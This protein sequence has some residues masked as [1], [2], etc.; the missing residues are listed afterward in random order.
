MKK[1]V[2][3]NVSDRGLYYIDGGRYYFPDRVAF[4]NARKGLAWV[5]V[6]KEKETFGFVSGYMLPNCCLVLSNYGSLLAKHGGYYWNVADIEGVKVAWF[7]DKSFKLF[8]NGIIYDN[9]G[10]LEMWMYDNIQQYEY[11][12]TLTLGYYIDERISSTTNMGDPKDCLDVEGW[13]YSKGNDLY[14]FENK[15]YM[16]DP[17][18]GC[19]NNKG[20]VVLG[21]HIMLNTPE[22]ADIWYYLEENYGKSKR[23][24]ESSYLYE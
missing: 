16:F 4:K 17:W 6:I 21:K 5:E 14:E 18:S 3:L 11:S 12:R 24:V 7:Y 9:F 23:L 20:V 22:T 2:Y 15:V 19:M 13:D 10:S 8:I 1:L